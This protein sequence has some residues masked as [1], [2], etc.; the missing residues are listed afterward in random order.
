MRAAAA[1]AAI[2]RGSSTRIFFRLRPVLRRRARAAPAWSCR[3]PG[4]AT[5]TAALRAR[6][7]RRQFRQRG[8][9]RKRLSAIA[10]RATSCPDAL[11]L[12]GR[13]NHR[14]AGSDRRHVHSARVQARWRI[15]RQVLSRGACQPKPKNAPTA[16]KRLQPP[17]QAR[18]PKKGDHV[19]LVD[20]SVLH[21]PRLSRAAAAHTASRTGCRSMPCSASATCCGSC[22]AT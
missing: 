8:I 7:C 14:S 15:R 10:H 22:C 12:L 17:V 3:R 13:R 11:R 19:F 5:S 1:R 20:G 21:L 2:R 9:D 4:G 16:P 18:P 6:K